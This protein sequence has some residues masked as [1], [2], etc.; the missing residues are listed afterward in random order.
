[1]SLDNINKQY[2]QAF[3]DL[4]DAGNALLVAAIIFLAGILIGLMNP[5]WGDDLISAVKGM[6]RH[7]SGKGAFIIIMVILSETAFP[8][9]SRS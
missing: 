9:R 7:I 8:P 2:S 5:P 4:R 3:L 6:A 1:M